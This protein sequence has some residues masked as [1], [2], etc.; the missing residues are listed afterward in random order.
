MFGVVLD[1]NMYTI[2]VLYYQSL[3]EI[4]SGKSHRLLHFFQ[5]FAPELF[6]PNK[7]DACVVREGEVINNCT[8]INAMLAN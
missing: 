5:H 2:I 3:H 4:L 6:M 8:G 7:I 1:W